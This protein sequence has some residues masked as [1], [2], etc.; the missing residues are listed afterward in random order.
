MAVEFVH[1]VEDYIRLHPRGR[2]MIANA[3]GSE[4]LVLNHVGG[5]KSR[6]RSFPSGGRAKDV[7]SGVRRWFPRVC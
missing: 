7:S 3:G 2:N 6:I 4:S 1:L 5:K